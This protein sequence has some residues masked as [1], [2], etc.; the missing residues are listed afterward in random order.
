LKT[1]YDTKPIDEELVM[2]KSIQE[3]IEKYYA[4]IED[5]KICWRK[6]P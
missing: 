4:T 3:W 1:C 5:A 2:M 6:K